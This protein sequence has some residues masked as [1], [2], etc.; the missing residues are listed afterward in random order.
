MPIPLFIVD[1]FT[2][3]PY[4]GNP[5]AVCILEQELSADRMQ[6]IAAEMNL[7]ETAFLLPRSKT[8]H[9]QWDLRW[10]SPV[11]EVDLC[12]HATLASAHLLWDLGIVAPE[13]VIEFSTRSGTL[14]CRQVTHAGERW[15]SMDFPNYT[16]DECAP[17]A[18][19]LEGLGLVSAELVW[20]GRTSADY[21]CV[22]ET[23]K[24]LRDLT[25]NFHLLG[26]LQTRGIIVTAPSDDP[27][28]AFVS[29]FFAPSAGIN[30]DPVTG[31]AHA[32]LGP[33][34][35]QQLGRSELVGFQASA[36]RGVV[37]LQVGEERIA[38]SGQAVTVLRGTIA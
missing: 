35:S 23:E 12:G 24:Q 7:S 34:W 14:E 6:S 8:G 25:P 27:S 19:L 28:F 16:L 11:Y 38:I 1:S 15:I 29:R 18:E 20:V 5:A 37:R 2:D 10:F 13:Q 36:R 31:S 4:S 3:R 33:Y 32:A 9:H 17:P 26:K 21:F 22:L 30:E